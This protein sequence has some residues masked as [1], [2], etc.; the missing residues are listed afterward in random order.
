M[1]EIPAYLGRVERMNSTKKR[2]KFLV[3]TA[4]LVPDDQWQYHL[5]DLPDG[6]FGVALSLKILTSSFTSS[7]SPKTFPRKAVARYF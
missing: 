5:K 2:G 3:M 1:N 4:T 7:A 6:L